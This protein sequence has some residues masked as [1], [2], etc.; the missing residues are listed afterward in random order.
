MCDRLGV[1]PRPG[2]E[3]DK[4]GNRFEGR[5]T[6]RHML[7]V[8]AANAESIVIEEPG[9]AGEGIEFSVVRPGDVVEAHQVKRQFGN[10]NS[11]SITTL[12]GLGVIKSAAKQVSRGREFHFV[13]MV[14]SRRLQEL[15][16]RSR[17]SD[18]FDVFRTSLTEGLRSEF[19]AFAG[20]VGTRGETFT[21]L[22]S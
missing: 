15:T 13:S 3:A 14:P 22:R 10:V 8:L 11:W 12:I 4:F 21:V 1:S 17:R 19:E 16:D 5:W 20:A 18:S 2:G 7:D 6:V 9:E